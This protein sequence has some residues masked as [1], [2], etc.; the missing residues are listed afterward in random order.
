MTR[1]VCAVLAALALAAL[2][3]SAQQQDFSQVQI[4][5]RRWDEFLTRSTARSA[6]S[7]LVGPD[8][9]FM[10]DSQ[11]APLTDEDRRRDQADF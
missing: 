1:T 8:G 7:R 3:V 10:V 2:S 4:R 11:F 5:R 6:R 9:V